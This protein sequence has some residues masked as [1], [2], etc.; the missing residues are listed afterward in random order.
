LSDPFVRYPDPRLGKAAP[1]QPFV[2]AAM[3]A[4]G[5][6]LLAAAREVKAY[7]LAAAHIGEVAPVVAI[8]RNGEGKDYFILYNARVASVA[9]ETT[10]GEEGSVSLPGIRLEIERPGWV[11]VDFMDESGTQKS[12]RFDG[13]AARVALHE[14]E[15]TQGIF[16]LDKV[17]RLKRD[18]ALKKARKQAG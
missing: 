10:K 3:L 17:S 8:S 18:M 14:I 6:R 7:G 16:F 13:F 1:P 4:I 5:A 2:D 11:T 15:Q 12:T 9:P